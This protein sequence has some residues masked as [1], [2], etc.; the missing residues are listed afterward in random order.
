MVDHEERRIWWIPL[1][2]LASRRAVEI[3]PTAG[4]AK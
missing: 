2:E 1:D 4:R 3:G